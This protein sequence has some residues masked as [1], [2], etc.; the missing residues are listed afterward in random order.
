MRRAV[1]ALCAALALD[2]VSTAS[3]EFL[4]PL[5]DP[6]AGSS[7][8]GLD[9]ALDVAPSIKCGDALTCPTTGAAACCHDLTGHVS[10]VETPAQC[11]AEGGVTSIQCGE[12]SDCPL[13]Q[14]CCAS[15]NGAIVH[16]GIDCNPDKGVRF[17]CYPDGAPAPE[18]PDACTNLQLAD[19]Q[20]LQTCR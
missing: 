14:P 11:Y 10:C 2:A 13:T 6:D 8:G 7:D 3:C 20:F 1:V 16:C 15:G 18:C 12:P 4:L 9:A 19:H 5:E 17:V